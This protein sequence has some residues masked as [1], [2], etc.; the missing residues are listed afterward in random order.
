M[1]TKE[2]IPPHHC[3][4]D[5]PATSV[6]ASL[7]D[8]ARHDIATGRIDFSDEHPKERA[9]FYPIPPAVFLDIQGNARFLKV[10]GGES[11][12]IRLIQDCSNAPLH[13][14]VAFQKDA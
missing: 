6:P 13:Y 4:G 7:Q 3:L 8:S 11:Y 5:T 9:F 1:S 10:E 12:S 2:S 14:H